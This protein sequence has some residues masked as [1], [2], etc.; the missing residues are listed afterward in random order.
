VKKMRIILASKS[1][2]RY[3]ILKGLGIKPEVIITNADE[4]I[5]GGPEYTVKELAARKAAAAKDMLGGET[6]LLIVAADTVVCFEDKILGKPVSQQDAFEALSMLSGKIHEVY[7]GLVLVYN[8]V[9]LCDFDVTRV[10]FKDLTPREIYL[11]IKTGDPM[12]RAGSYGAEGAGAAFIERIEGDFF[13]IAGLPVFK[14]VK[15][16]EKG[17]GLSIFDLM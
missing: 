5:N 9:T 11:Y 13:N 1:P 14:F 17:F 12:S 16:L 3:N 2:T 15:M 4:N 10:K 6:G 7:S 8:S